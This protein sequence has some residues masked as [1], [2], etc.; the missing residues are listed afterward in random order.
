MLYGDAPLRAAVVASAANGT[1]CPQQQDFAATKTCT[2]EAISRL[3]KSGLPVGWVK[4]VS[5]RKLLWP[6]QRS[7]LGFLLTAAAATMG[8]PFWFDQL[9]R[10]GSLRNTGNKP[11][12]KTS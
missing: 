9:N 12:S 3:A 10:L 8:A 6:P 1:L 2:N 7:W 11:T 5:P 4:G